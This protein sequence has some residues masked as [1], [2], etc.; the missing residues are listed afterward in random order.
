MMNQLNLQLIKGQKKKVSIFNIN[1]H[2]HG[3]VN[4]HWILTFNVVSVVF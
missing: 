1:I 4:T 2:S 3:I